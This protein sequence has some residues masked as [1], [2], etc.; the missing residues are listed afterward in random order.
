MQFIRY[1]GSKT[2]DT[3]YK[4]I[5]KGILCKRGHKSTTEQYLSK[6][7]INKLMLEDRKIHRIK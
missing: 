1:F 5:Y 3:V 4:Q 2:R 6:N 7:W